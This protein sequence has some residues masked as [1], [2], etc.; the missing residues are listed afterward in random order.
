MSNNNTRICEFDSNDN[1]IDNNQ[2][3]FIFF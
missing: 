1:N 3:F 2:F